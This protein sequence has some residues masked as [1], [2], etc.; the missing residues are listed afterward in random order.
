[1]TDDDLRV[2]LGRLVRQLVR[3]TTDGDGEK[4]APALQAHLGEGAS[5]L[6][7]LTEELQPWELP[8][9]Q[10]AL[11]AVLARD[12]WTARILGLSAHARHYGL[13][14]GDL[15]HGGEWGAA[16]GPPD[17]VNAAVGPDRTLACLTFAILLV[18]SPTG[19]MVLFVRRGQAHP[20]MGEATLDIQVTAVREGS[21]TEFVAELKQLMDEHDVYRG[22][23][24]T[25]LVD[26]MRGS[27]ISFVERPKMSTDE[28]VLPDGVMDS[29]QRHVVGVSLHRDTLVAAGRHLSRGILLWGPP[30]TGKTHTV[31]Y[32]AS[33]RT[34]ATVII[35][36]GPA[37]GMAGGFVTMARR[38][39]PSMLIL[40]DVD[41]VAQERTFGPFGASSPVLFELM[42]QMDGLGG[43]A[44][45]AFVLTTNRAD[46]L[47]PALAARPGRIDL[48]VE[49]PLPDEQG[50]ERLLE[51]YGR[52]LELRLENPAAVV[53][54]T[55]GVTASFIKELLRAAMLRAADEN[56]AHIRDDDIAV[57]LDDLLSDRA[58]LTRVLLGGEKP[59]EPADPH[60][61]MVGG[62]MTSFGTSPTAIDE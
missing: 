30:G 55:A 42:N 15:I 43:D 21:A 4:L 41:L 54:R 16:A 26:P 27:E 9:L 19:A 57:V 28:L 62:G 32:L 48:A 61:W 18:D 38:L 35:I 1:M 51:L 6:P 46:A 12:G 60:S 10:L 5:D 2:Q 36:S 8:N 13:S 58:T 14:L 34:D 49:I 56:R 29:I 3:D 47:E 52:G 25:V 7:I 44:D 53:E 33:V 20:G 59:T 50:R 39:Q 22:Q 17:Y 31:R 37:L 40:E 24:L 11:D 45:I 23:V